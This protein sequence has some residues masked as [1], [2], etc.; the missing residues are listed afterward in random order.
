MRKNKLIHLFTLDELQRRSEIIRSITKRIKLL[1]AHQQDRKT[2]L[3]NTQQQ[4]Q[5]VCLKASETNNHCQDLEEKNQSLNYSVLALS[6]QVGRLK[7]GE[8]ELSTLL[9]LKPFPLLALRSQECIA[10]MTRDHVA[11]SQD[12]DIAVS[13]DCYMITGYCRKALLGTERREEHRDMVP[14]LLYT[15]WAVLCTT[16]LVLYSAWP[17]LYTTWAVL[18]TTY[19][20]NIVRGCV[21]YFVGCA[22]YYTGCAIYYVGCAI[23]YV[24]VQYS[25]GSVIYCVGCAVYYV[26]C[27]IYYVG[28][29]IYYVAVLYTTFDT[30]PH[31][32]HY[33]N[34]LYKQNNSDAVEV[35]TFSF[36]LRDKDI[37]EATNHITE[38]TYRLR[39]LETALR[40]TRLKEASAKKEMQGLK[41]RIKGLETELEKLNGM[42]L[43]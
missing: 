22:T 7:A 25:T 17:V 19:L 35:Q 29:V 26:G 27:A 16:W 33:H 15:M 40:E 39:D 5:E 41:P 10:A 42:G 2:K 32:R 38:F 8:Q 23:Y 20:C 31:K 43:L 3:E 28:C 13:R 18:Y 11:V 1:E 12:D 21:I 4:L 14:T 6:A 9:K 37:I 36:H 30:V 34:E 24:P